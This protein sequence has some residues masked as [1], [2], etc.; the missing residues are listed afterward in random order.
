[1]NVL[2]IAGGSILLAALYASANAALTALTEARLG[3]VSEGTGALAR[4][5]LRTRQFRDGIRAR[6]LVGRVL[7]LSTAAASI[8]VLFVRDGSFW[9]AL[10]GSTL[11][12][13]VYGLIAQIGTAI[14]AARGPLGQLRLLRAVRVLELLMAPIAAPLEIVGR[15]A[16]K[17]VPSP[18]EDA[19]IQTRAIEHMIEKGEEEG[20]LPEEH[21]AML[22]SVLEFEDTIA[23]EVMVPRTQMVS[24]E[25][26]TPLEQVIERI[27]ETGHSRYPVYR[28]NVDQVE[29]LLY[30]K[31]LFRVLRD[32]KT[33]PDLESLIRTPIAFIP[34]VR[35]IGA[36]LREMQ[37]HRFH[38]GVV[39]DEFG[40]VAGLV[41]LEDIL[42]EIVGEIEDEH[43]D[44][45]KRVS[46]RAPG[47]YIADATISVHD[48]A[49]I[50]GEP[51]A[52]TSGS[53]DSL[54]GMIVELAGRV[55]AVGEQIS[56]GAFDLRILEAD[57]RH[58]QQVEIVRRPLAL[59][60]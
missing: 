5:A 33:D 31:D 44:E 49:E 8:A 54:G 24:F 43:D 21:A 60:Q 50:I 39:V 14:M 46:E 6:L 45:T 52:E 3:A 36:V 59:A 20:A 17:L 37:T 16:A 38:L 7:S 10:A 28:E 40:G 51:L 26:T 9:M 42:E 58:V 4:E 41:T 23:R 15:L 53:Y 12:A 29:G 34:E 11:A 19:D 2:G 56:S 27:E 22:R 32:G 47:H 48:L 25:M 57:E 30:A 13:L 55:P 18:A 35:K 1:M